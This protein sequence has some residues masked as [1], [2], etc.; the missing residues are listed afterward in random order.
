MLQVTKVFDDA[1]TMIDTV[2]EEAIEL[3]KTRL[4]LLGTGLRSMLSVTVCDG[5]LTP[6]ATVAAFGYDDESDV[7]AGLLYTA[8]RVA[9]KLGL[10]VE[11]HQLPG[12]QPPKDDFDK[13][14]N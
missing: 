12:A 6:N 7:L 3:T 14:L 9:E 11:I 13:W 4:E 5:I 10:R 2:A 1:E 8:Q